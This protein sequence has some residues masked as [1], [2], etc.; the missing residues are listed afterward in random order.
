MGG[1]VDLESLPGKST[2]VTL[3]LPLTVGSEGTV[4]RLLLADDH[5]RLE[6]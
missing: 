2:T 3:I 5:N 4:R 6:V 1:R